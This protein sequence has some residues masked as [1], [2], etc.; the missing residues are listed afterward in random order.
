M[1]STDSADGGIGVI[2]CSTL[3]M[4]TI[5][6]LALSLSLFLVIMFTSGITLNTLSVFGDFFLLCLHQGA[7][8]NYKDKMHRHQKRKGKTDVENLLDCKLLINVNMINFDTMN[9][10]QFNTMERRLNIYVKGILELG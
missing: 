5:Q 9:S 3:Q 10:S 2:F 4:N 8:L 7:G 1:Q 6:Y